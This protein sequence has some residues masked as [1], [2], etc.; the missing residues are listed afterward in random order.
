MSKAP[1]YIDAARR[2]IR[3]KKRVLFVEGKDDEAVYSRWLSKLDAMFTAK[4]EIVQVGGRNAL[5]RALLELGNPPEAHAIRDRD[6]W[7]LPRTNAS[8]GQMPNFHVVSTRHSLESYF[9]DPAEIVPVLQQKNAAAY[10]PRCAT[11]QANLTAAKDA[12]VD[13]WALWTTTMR[14]EGDMVSTGYASFFNDVVP[15]PSDVDIQARMRDWQQLVEIGKVF[16]DFDALRS[17][18]RA[19][20]TS[21][22]FRGCVYGKGFWSKVVEPEL[23]II[24]S[25]NSWFLDLADWM[26]A[27]GDIGVVLQA[28][29][30]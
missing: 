21:E 26:S 17:A 2:A 8:V 7:D 23:R 5:E 14:L 10:G 12:W 22:Q 6:E 30:A 3:V 4:V 16:G 15:L 28:L 27:P 13:H 9:T 25:R 29:L 20:P 18:A 24:D 1:K 19:R 11:F